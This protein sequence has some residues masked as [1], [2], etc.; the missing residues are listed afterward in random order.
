MKIIMVLLAVVFTC[1]LSYAQSEV[2]EN[3]PMLTQTTSSTTL[4][5]KTSTTTVR[6]E[7]RAQLNFEDELVEGS[8]QKPELFYLFQKKNFNYKRLIKLRENFLPEMRRS[9]EDVQRV[10]GGN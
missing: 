5:N 10:R 9:A 1:E 2:A 3:E 6:K 7:R 4:G 8:T